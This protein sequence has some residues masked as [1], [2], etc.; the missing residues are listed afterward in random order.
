MKNQ[1]ILVPYVKYAK[2]KVEIV[3]VIKSKGQSSRVLPPAGLVLGAQ[4]HFAIGN[5]ILHFKTIYLLGE[6]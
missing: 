5:E 6:L 2:P 1:H 4:S 3:G